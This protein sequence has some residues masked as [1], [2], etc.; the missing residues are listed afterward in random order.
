MQMAK[1]RGLLFLAAI[2]VLV[3]SGCSTE[4]NGPTELSCLVVLE[5]DLVDM[6]MEELPWEWDVD[7]QQHLECFESVLENDPNNDDA[8]LMAAF[9]RTMVTAGDE[10]LGR[11]MEELF[12]DETRS[13]RHNA[14]FWYL[15]LPDPE[16]I[17][18]VIRASRRGDFVFS[19]IQEF[20]TDEVLPSLNEV[21]VY[22]STFEELGGVVVLYTDPAL[23]DS[24]QLPDYLEFD[25]A[26]AYFVHVA[27]DIMQA[28]C[29]LGISYNA[30]TT[31]AENLEYL[32]EEDADF[33][34]LNDADFM[35]SA[36]AELMGAVYH[37]RDACD[38][39]EGES[40]DQEWDF[41]TVSEPGW[42]VLEDDDVLGPGAVET[43]RDAADLLEEV[44]FGE[45]IVNL[46]EYEDDAPDIDIHVSLESLF[47][48]PLPDLRSYLPWHT[49]SV[50]GDTMYVTEPITFPDPEFDGPDPAYGGIFPGMTNDT[51]RLLV[52][53]EEKH[54]R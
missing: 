20:I 32:I 41:I 26:D 28:L 17:R 37:L 2:L 15:T 33:L 48:D 16:A 4:E 6:D 38:A 24:L 52:D 47:N 14:L 5:A 39:L 49:W 10:E 18:S 11:I 45:G 35:S 43:L 13:A 9:C 36:E 46:H 54:W 22:L 7:F 34:T 30:D 40:D 51:W 19:D 12:G 27:V 23:P 50:D 53:W 31:G 1:L 29:Y 42:V 44:L 25:V 21:D 8:L 3:G